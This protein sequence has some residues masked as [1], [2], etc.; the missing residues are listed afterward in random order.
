MEAQALEPDTLAPWAEIV[1]NTPPMTVEDLLEYPGDDGWQYEL[2]E[3]VL[4]RMVGARPR[5]MRVT[6]RL[7]G[8]LNT[9]V[10]A[11]ALGQVT[12]PDTVYDFEK[13]GQR[14]TGLLPDIGFYVAAREPLIDP[15]K[16]IPFAP[17]LAVEVA[18]PTQYRPAMK[19]KAERYLAGGTALVWIVW[20]TRRQVDVWRTG[21]A[22]PSATLGSDAML[23][24]E[25]VVPGFRYPVAGLFQ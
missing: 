17:D 20:P 16:A 21:D 23:D 22:Q 19:A 6:M 13:T 11:H 4:V 2:V 9:Y 18:S 14:D 7:L 3:R 8:A 25:G 1:P 12:P 5:A 10:E 15:D 24:G